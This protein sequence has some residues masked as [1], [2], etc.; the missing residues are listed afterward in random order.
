MYYTR[1]KE[2]LQMIS[3]QWDIS[4]EKSIPYY[5]EVQKRNF[6]ERLKKVRNTLLML[7]AYACPNNK[8]RVQLHRWR[9]VHIGKNVYLGMFCFLDNLYPSY[10][11]IED[12]ASINAGAMILTHFDPMSH[13]ASVFQARV[14]PVLIKKCAI[15]AVRSTIMPGVAIG[16]YSVVSAGAVVEKDVDD[17][18]MVKGVPARMVAEYKSL[19]EE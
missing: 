5:E 15:V 19:I 18:T 4:S 1:I 12:N 13:Y 16:R 2:F 9:G 6:F 10:I 17:Y 11:Y 3:E 8:C 7:L 14:A